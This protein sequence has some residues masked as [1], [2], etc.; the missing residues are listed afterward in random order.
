MRIHTGEKP[1]ACQIC[2]NRYS[3]SGQLAAHR[4]THLNQPEQLKLNKQTSKI[5]IQSCKIQT[6]T[7]IHHEQQLSNHDIQVDQQNILTPVRQLIQIF[8]PNSQTEQLVIEEKKITDHIEASVLSTGQIVP[9]LKIDSDH[10]Q[11]TS[12]YSELNPLVPQFKLDVDETKSNIQTQLI[13]T[14]SSQHNQDETISLCI[15]SP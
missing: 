2:G 4:K 14:I 11:S 5:Q 6:L 3:Q 7:S 9:V 12:F 15:E 1:Y 10:I 13:T 8:N